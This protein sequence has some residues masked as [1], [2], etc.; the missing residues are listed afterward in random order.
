MF[1]AKLNT[2]VT[3]EAK[4]I[5]GKDGSVEDLGVICDSDNNDLELIVL[6]KEKELEKQKSILGGNV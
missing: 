3:I 5:R 6:E 2:R 4:I 1:T